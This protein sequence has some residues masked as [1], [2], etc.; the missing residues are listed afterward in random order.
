MRHG[1]SWVCEHR[2]TWPLS[3]RWQP[4]VAVAHVNT[5]SRLGDGT[6]AGTAMIRG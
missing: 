2:L 1:P 5:L 3:R 6:K 4:V